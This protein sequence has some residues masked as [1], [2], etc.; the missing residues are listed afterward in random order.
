MIRK[1]ALWG[2]CPGDSFHKDWPEAFGDR[3]KIICKTF[4]APGL[5]YLGWIAIHCF[6]IVIPIGEDQG[7]LLTFFIFESF[8]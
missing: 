3:C 7:F 4:V 1:Y 6:L 8:F 2:L 5:S